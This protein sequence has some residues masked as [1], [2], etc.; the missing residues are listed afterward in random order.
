VFYLLHNPS[1]LEKL[2]TEV[3][4]KFSAVED[5]RGGLQLASC[6]YLRACIDEAMRMSPPQVGVFFREAQAGGVTIDGHYFPRGTDLGVSPYVIHH[7]EEIYPDSFRYFP[8]RWIVDEATGITAKAVAFAQSAFCPFSIGPRGCLGKSF[9]YKE[10]MTVIARLCLMYDMRLAP[11]SRSGEGHA[12]L[13]RGRHRPDELQLDDKLIGKPSGPMLQFKA[14]LTG[15]C[16][17]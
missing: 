11:G 9:A 17:N 2:N 3:R 10:M 14:R 12:S 4:G 8:E 1:V 7:N 15:V 5:I 13:G 16:N 6:K